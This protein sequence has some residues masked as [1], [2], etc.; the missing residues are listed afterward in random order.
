MANQRIRD[1]IW[2]PNILAKRACTV[3][4]AGFAVFLFALSFLSDSRTKTDLGSDQAATDLVPLTLLRNAHQKGAFCLDGSVP[5]YHFQKGFGSGSRNW[6]LHIEGGGWCN[7]VASCSYRQKTVLGSSN[8]VEHPIQFS[9]ILSRDP[10]QNPDFFSW[11]KVKIRYCDGGSFA[12]NPESEFKN[13]TKLFFRGQLIWE[14]LMDQLLSVGLSDARQALLSGCS[15]G[16]LATLIHCDD[17]RNIL[18]AADVKCL[19]DAGFFL[20][21]KDIAGN[22]TIEAFYHEVVHLQGITESLKRDCVKKM[23]PSKCFFPQ[24]FISSIKTPVFL[25]NPAYDFWQI[26]NILLPVASDP[27]GMWSKCKLNIKYCSPT[28]VEVLQGYRNLL[29]KALTEYHQTKDSGMFIN[30]CYVHCQTWM[31]QTWHAPNSPRI[32]NKTIAESVGDWYFN[33]AAKHIQIDCP[34]PCN[35]TC[36]NMDFTR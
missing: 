34:Y 25:V 28:Q 26:Q 14:A 24:E 10:L 23:E 15:A 19:S 11:N 27:H 5:G 13:G 2:R 17:F 4:A 30:S 33:R 35:P 16:A 3:A 1:L 18:P 29:L 32:N 8:Y 21:A 7:T 9:G 20:N 22:R 12:G 6:V 36:Y 31:T